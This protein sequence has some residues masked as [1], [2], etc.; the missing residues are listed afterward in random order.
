MAILH[1][2]NYMFD[3][4]LVRYINEFLEKCNNC[5]KYDIY[6]EIRICFACRKYFCNCCKMI[7]DYT[8]Y[9]VC[10]LYCEE[11]HNKYFTNNYI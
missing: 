7:R 3:P 6:N 4:Y 11:C 8:P 2:Y 5:G 10:G 1:F 9:E